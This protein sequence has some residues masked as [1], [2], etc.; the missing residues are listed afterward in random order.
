MHPTTGCEVTQIAAMGEE[1]SEVYM[2]LS[3][4]LGAVADMVD[5]ALIDSDKT[6]K[7]ENRLRNTGGAKW[8]NPSLVYGRR[9]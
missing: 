8:V 4:L 6:K 7:L 1:A 3:S 9:T 5:G 2:A